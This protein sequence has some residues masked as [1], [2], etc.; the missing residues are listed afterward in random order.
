MKGI[1]YTV[2]FFFLLYNANNRD[3]ILRIH[4]SLSP[5]CFPSKTF[6]FYN[7][8]NDFSDKL[9]IHSIM[10]AHFGSS[11]FDIEVHVFYPVQ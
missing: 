6:S 7:D 5:I 11:N 2:D 1:S 4:S 10:G 8:Y 9:T 3:V